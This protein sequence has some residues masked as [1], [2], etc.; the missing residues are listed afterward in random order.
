VV[1]VPHHMRTARRAL[2]AQLFAWGRHQPGG[3]RRAVPSA[4]GY[5]FDLPRP[6]QRSLWGE[7]CGCRTVSQSGGRATGH[8]SPSAP[9]PTSRNAPSSVPGRIEIG[10]PCAISWDAQNID[11]DYDHIHGREPNAPVVIGDEVWIGARAM[12][13]KGVT[14]GDGAIISAGAVVTRDVP[15]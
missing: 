13:L 8:G 14:I 11:T 3:F 6:A 4:G 9:A 2:G 12:I 10:A 7:G 15:A 1:T 5:A